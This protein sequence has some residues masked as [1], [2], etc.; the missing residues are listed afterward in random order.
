MRRFAMWLVLNVP[1]GRLAP[2]GFGFAVNSRPRKATERPW[3]VDRDG[4]IRTGKDRPV[5]LRGRQ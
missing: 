3:T 5:V 2:W 4:R 1:L